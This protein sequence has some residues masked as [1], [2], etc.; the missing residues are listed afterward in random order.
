LAILDARP[1]VALSDPSN[2]RPQ[3][4]VT[5]FAFIHFHDMSCDKLGGNSQMNSGASIGRIL[6]PLVSVHLADQMEVDGVSNEIS[7]SSQVT[8][9]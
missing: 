8:P 2:Q 7:H 6:S 3:G 1:S 9:L 5:K 4:V